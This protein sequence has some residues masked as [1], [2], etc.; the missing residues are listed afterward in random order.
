METEE[1][2]YHSRTELLEELKG[3]CKSH[4]KR[5]IYGGL[6]CLIVAILY[7]FLPIG[8]RPNEIITLL[9]F[10]I[11]IVISCLSAWAALINYRLLKR[12]DELDT[13]D[14]LLYHLEKRHRYNMIFLAIAWILLL[15]SDIIVRNDSWA[16]TLTFWIVVT[17]I[18]LFCYYKNL[19]WI[20]EEKEM[21]RQ[22]K[23]L[24]EK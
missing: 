17:V 23:E 16:L 12:I 2:D 18:I 9:F 24:A 1:L 11:W 13:P 15:C 7:L 3:K 10:I 5:D 22:L 8:E 14:Q 21:I 6:F 20:G 19:G 4:A